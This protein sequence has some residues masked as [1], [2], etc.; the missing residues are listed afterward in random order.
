LAFLAFLAMI[1][2]S[3]GAHMARGVNI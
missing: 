2:C 3:M 1:A